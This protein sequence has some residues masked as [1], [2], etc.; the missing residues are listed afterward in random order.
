MNTKENEALLQ[1]RINELE[2]QLKEKDKVI[3]KKDDENSKLK[4]KVNTLSEDNLVMKRT[5]RSVD[6]KLRLSL[7]ARF[8]SKS[9]KY[10]KLF[11]IPKTYFDLLDSNK[12]DYTKE[13]LK[14]LDEGKKVIEKL[15]EDE[16]KTLINK[17]NRNPKKRKRG[18]SNGKQKFDES[19]P[20]KEVIVDLSNKEC[21]KCGCELIPL[22]IYSQTEYV[23]LLEKSLEIIREKRPK[24]YCPNCEIKSNNTNRE[25]TKTIICAPSP[26]DRFIPGGLTGNNLIATSIIDKYFY[27]L[28]AYRLSSRFRHFGID[29]SEQNLS[30]WFIKAA[31][32]LTP[33]ADEIL[34]EILSGP[35]INADETSYMV[36]DEEARKDTNKSWMWVL[37]SSDINNPKVYFKYDPSRSSDVFKSLVGDYSGYV[38]SDAYAGY[39]TKKQNYKFK[40]S[41][42]LSH[43]R[44]R[45]VEAKI[46]GDYKEGSAGYIT[47]NKILKIIGE[48]YK[49]DKEQRELLNKKIIT[50]A[51]FIKKRKA[52]SE[53]QF[54]KLTRVAVGR[55]DYH[56]NDES[57]LDGIDYYINHQKLFP[58]YLQTKELTP[59]NNIVE[60]QIKAFSR[61]R[62]N[63]LFAG[64]PSGAKAM[65]TIQTIIQTAN[66]N[67]L[68]LEKYM[69]F[70]LEKISLM[71]DKLASEVNYSKLLPWN[72]DKQTKSILLIDTMSIKQKK[73]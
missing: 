25:N 59:D 60:Q 37:Y 1:M 71:R 27:G 33:I 63:T 72:L 49:I 58:V 69:K 40:L 14:V 19:Y 18:N 47:I 44:R 41:L 50:D 15:K 36:L 9:E 30:N 68:D 2:K 16:D 10:R 5:I 28:S 73:F 7:F 11:N 8:G 38:K 55:R 29:I 51:E 56:L 48:I 43:L 39:Q 52:L 54:D 22:N 35:A 24:Y 4:D 66:L 70:L 65:A 62:K 20:R 31:N 53:I 34:K 13:E 46:G 42:C 26:K 57:I 12:S 3:A 67:D 17:R 21:P 6:E 64:S 45:F 32:E 61:V 23:E